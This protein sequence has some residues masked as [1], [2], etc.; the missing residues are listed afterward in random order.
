MPASMN[1]ICSSLKMKL[2]QKFKRL[3][4]DFCVFDDH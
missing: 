1:A 3:I 4:I 2:T